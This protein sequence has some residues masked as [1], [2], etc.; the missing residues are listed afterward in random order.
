LKA[1]V[2]HSVGS[3]SGVVADAADLAQ[4]RLAS[5]LDRRLVTHS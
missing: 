2:W 5:C 1:C 4:C 3:P